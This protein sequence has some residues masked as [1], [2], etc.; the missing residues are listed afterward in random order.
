MLTYLPRDF[1]SSHGS[2]L[3]TT[4]DSSL[5]TK[6]KHNLPLKTFKEDE[7]S[8]MLLKYLERPKPENDPEREIAQEISG[9]VGGLPVA[10]SHVAGY[11]AYS[12]CSLTELLEIFKQRR[13]H[14]GSATSEDDDLPASFRQASFSY[15]ET[16]SMVWNVTLRELTSD[17]RDLTYIL[18]YLN[19]EA[20]PESML[21][22]VHPEPSLEFLDAREEIRCVLSIS[23]HFSDC[24]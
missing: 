8:A 13:R 24:C 23:G 21:C 17:A 18:A 7:G 9:L 10:I 15:D 14:I 19:C 22:A 6:V 2:V 16:L 20:V 4:Q 1:Y 5:A 3:I 11:V 12:Q